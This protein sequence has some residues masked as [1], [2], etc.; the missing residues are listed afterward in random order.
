MRLAV[1]FQV[2]RRVGLFAQG[3]VAAAVFLSPPLR[4]A[5]K[6]GR[7]AAHQLRERACVVRWREQRK[8]VGQL[9]MRGD[10]GKDERAARPE[11]L[12]NGA[13]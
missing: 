2:A 1:N 4:R 6:A 3:Q 8:A 9:A 5:V 13:F 7:R 12:G 10:V 11:R